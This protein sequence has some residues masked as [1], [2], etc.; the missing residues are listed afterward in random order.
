[1]DLQ[2]DGKSCLVTGASAGI[3][4]AIARVMAREGATVWVHGF[5]LAP[6]EAVAQA[7]REG[8]IAK[9]IRERHQLT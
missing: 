2:L 3:G 4:S 8:R 7:R 1:M 5:E 6:A 9:R